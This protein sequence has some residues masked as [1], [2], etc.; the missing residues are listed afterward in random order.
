MVENGSEKLNSIID[1]LPPRGTPTSPLGM[2]CGT[3]AAASPLTKRTCVRPKGVE[4]I[5][6]LGG[7]VCIL[8]VCGGL[9]MRRFNHELP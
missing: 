4:R 3:G 6:R 1:Q 8:Q 9:T 2:R 7:L 5:G